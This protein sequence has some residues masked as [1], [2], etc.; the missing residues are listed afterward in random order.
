MPSI[1]YTTAAKNAR[2]QAVA[3]AI[4]AGSGAGYINICT[5]GYGTI[6]ATIN[7]NDPCATATDGVLTFSGFPKSTTASAT[8]TAAIARIRT[9]ANADCILDISVGLPGSGADM[10]LAT[11]AITSGGTVT[12][13]SLSIVHP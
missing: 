11:T 4:D 3:D 8:G 2:L 1:T 13:D 10:I 5:A 6:L 9:S 12:I 7:L